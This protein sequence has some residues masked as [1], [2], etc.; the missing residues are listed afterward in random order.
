M[1]DFSCPLVE[2]QGFGKHK[3][4]DT[5]N[6]T[7]V[8]GSCCIFKEGAFKKGDWAVF[9]PVN[10]V[11]P[12]DHPAF[13]WLKDPKKPDAKTHRVKARRLRGVFSDGF[14]VPVWDLRAKL[15]AEVGDE[16]VQ[17]FERVGDTNKLVAMTLLGGVHVKLGQDCAQ[18]LGVTKHEEA[19][20]PHMNTGNE[21]DP[22]FMPTYNVEPWKKY[23]GEFVDGEEVVVT[24]KIHGCNSRFAFRDGRLYVAS[25]HSYK[26]EDERNLWWAVAFQYGLVEKMQKLD[27]YALYGEV[28][29]D[30][31]QDLKYGC[32]SGERKFVA[33]DLYDMKN[34]VFLNYDDFCRLTS[35]HGIPRAP[36]LYRGPYS[37]TLVEFHT[38]PVEEEGK[39]LLSALDG[40]T[41][42]EGIVIRTAVERWNPSTRRTNMKHVSQAYL[43][44]KG[45]TELH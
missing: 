41:L 45:G 43:L 20:P 2:I 29:G 28:Y 17:H 5:L 15:V 42:R 6:I 38:N 4:A 8:E 35:E 1:S 27:G 9:I 19:L 26:T 16:E 31:I 37:P 30:G 18:L 13:E 12:L 34:G 14:L 21:A 40:K 7:Q 24:E 33:F 22:G 25:H 23:K 32:A 44:R 39:P 11:V 36:C 10:S 3:N